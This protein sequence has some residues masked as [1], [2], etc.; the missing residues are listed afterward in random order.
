VDRHEVLYLPPFRDGNLWSLRAEGRYRPDGENVSGVYFYRDEGLV[1]PRLPG[2]LRP[3]PLPAMERQLPKQTWYYQSRV[4]VAYPLLCLV[5]LIPP[6]VWLRGQRS[7]RRRKRIEA[8]ECPACGYDLRATPGRCPEC[9][10][11]VERPPGAT[12]GVAGVPPEA[13]ADCVSAFQS[14]G[15]E[16][17]EC[18]A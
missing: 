11:S 2:E 17:I 16:A 14:A 13:T 6:A 7:R 8:G 1:R 3:P 5:T 4:G 18:D 12:G 9:G 15:Q 10:T